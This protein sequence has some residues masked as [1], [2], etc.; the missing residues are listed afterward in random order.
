MRP[1]LAQLRSNVP[2]GGYRPK[3][4]KE[5]QALFRAKLLLFFA[6]AFFGEVRP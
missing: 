6:V 4:T 1:L 5:F 3:G 2:I